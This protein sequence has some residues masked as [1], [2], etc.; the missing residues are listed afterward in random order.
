MF[1]VDHFGTPS[2]SPVNLP[3]LTTLTYTRYGV[4]HGDKKRSLFD[5][6]VIGRRKR[7]IHTRAHYHPYVLEISVTSKT[8]R[9]ITLN[10]GTVQ[11]PSRSCLMT[12]TLKIDGRGRITTRNR[13]FLRRFTPASVY[14]G[15]P[16]SP[17]F[18]TTIPTT[19]SAYPQPTCDSPETVEN[20][21]S[22]NP[23]M[24]L[25]QTRPETPAP[26]RL[27]RNR[28]PPRRYEPETGRWI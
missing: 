19:G 14:I 5:S 8:K 9:G 27:Q 20:E 13:R 22:D 11:E 6:V 7:L 25:V 2:L 15:A 17:T 21:R 18:L 23:L 12:P 24:P 28:H 16:V 26:G 4:R 3:N 1:L 10:V